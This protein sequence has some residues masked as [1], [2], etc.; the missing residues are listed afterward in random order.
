MPQSGAGILWL[1]WNGF[2]GGDPYYAGVDMSA[3]VVNTNIATAVG[4]ITWMAM[5]A[6]LSKSKK[7]TFLGGVNG[8]IVG[9]VGITPS[10]GWVNGWGAIA[11]G[12]FDTVIV[13]VAWNYLVKMRPFSKVDDAL[14]VIYTHGIA[15]F[16]GGLF[17]G[18]FA[19]PNMVEYG[20]GTLNTSGQVINTSNAAYLA[21][22]K[23]CTPFSVQGLM[24]TGSFHQLW[25]QFR[26]AIFV[27]F[28]SALVTFILM[29]LI[30]LVLRGNRYKDEILEV[31]DVAI[32]DEE[33][34]PV[35]TLAERV[36][37]LSMAG[38][39]AET[40]SARSPDDPS[41]G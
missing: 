26:A 8:M 39:G 30:G 4:I 12:F 40:S 23:S 17:V 3:A 33:A 22:T 32:H 14:G 9:L 34:Y 19:D 35:E 2:N 5:D 15:G 27:I 1:G 28:W 41:P 16:F 10:A 7:P 6:V 24:Y 25:E 18:V 36:G 29:K 31:G 38:A 13:W 20:C 21:T 37:A 11:V